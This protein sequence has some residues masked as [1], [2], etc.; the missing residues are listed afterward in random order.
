M[1]LSQHNQ[2]AA[3]CVCV[4]VCVCGMPLDLS[5]AFVPTAGVCSKP[6]SADSRAHGSE[7]RLEGFKMEKQRIFVLLQ[8]I[9]CRRVSAFPVQV[10]LLLPPPSRRLSPRSYNRLPNNQRVCGLN[11]APSQSAVVS[12]GKTLDPKLAAWVKHLGVP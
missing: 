11:P 8:P 2:S 4:C 5:A 12:L 3:A 7:R 10:I 1:R 6:V 9:G